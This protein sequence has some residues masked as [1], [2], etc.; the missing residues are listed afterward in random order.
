MTSEV[1]QDVVAGQA[2][3]TKA[4]LAMYDLLVLGVSNPFIWKCPTPRPSAT[5]SRPKPEMCY[6]KT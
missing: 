5:S 3:Y 4:I 6:Y 2:V 1:R